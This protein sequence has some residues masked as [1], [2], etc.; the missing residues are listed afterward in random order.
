MLS[1]NKI[2]FTKTGKLESI[3][4][5]YIFKNKE[6]ERKGG[7]KEKLAETMTLTYRGWLLVGDRLAIETAQTEE[8]Q[9]WI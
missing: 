8:R 6:G 9:D 1:C 5:I 3:K 4:Y 7:R 2:L